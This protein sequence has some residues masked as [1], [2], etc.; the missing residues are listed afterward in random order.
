MLSTNER[1]KTTLNDWW[2]GM[3][4]VLAIVAAYQG[5]AECGFINLD[6]PSHV[7]LNPA[8]TQG[9]SWDGVVSAFT[10]PHASLWVPLTTVS[11]MADVSTFG[12]SARAMHL[13][14]L[15]W[16]A[17]ATLLLYFSMRALTGSQWRSAL[18]A[19]LFGLHPINVES[20]AWIAERKNVLCAFFSFAMLRCWASYVQKRS[21]WGW[22]CALLL[23]AAALLAKP[24]AVTLP[25]A[26]LLLD[27]WPLKRWG[28][29]RWWSLLVEKA[30]LFALS[31]IT[32]RLALWAADSRE[33]VPTLADL[34]LEARLS[35]AITSIGDYVLDLLWP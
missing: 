12:L 2:I 8:V 7:Y 5:V 21:A 30:P 9:L 3:V 11:F 16:H 22:F 6:D 25:F 18:V 28:R 32:S 14:N 23:F 4:V 10:T 27:W 35:N 19:T 26:L 1:G 31:F 20:V 17:G 33:T 29:V 13:E 15:A 24:M 34:T